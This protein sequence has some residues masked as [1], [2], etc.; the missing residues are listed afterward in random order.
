MSITKGERAELLSLIRKRE[1]VA[2]AGAEQ[3]SA[4]LLADFEQ[5]I[6]AVFHWADDATWNA[7]YAAAEEACKAA[8][9]AIAERSKELGIPAEFTPSM[10]W[11]WARRGENELANRRAEL[12]RV[13]K[14]EIANLEARAK[15]RI[16]ADSAQ[17]QSDILALGEL[18]PAA[19]EFLKSLAPADTLMP[20]LT[21]ESVQDRLE[22]QN[23]T[24]RLTGGFH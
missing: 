4:A 14:A 3:R 18:T 21:I 16:E 23:K 2:K 9:K 19:R 20:E 17:A 15:A 1:R 11:A 8:N 12:R 10:A 5:K 22:A 7:A 24:R 6:A 13:A